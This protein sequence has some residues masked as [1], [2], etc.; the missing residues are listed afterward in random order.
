MAQEEATMAQEAMMDLMP[1]AQIA[2]LGFL[3]RKHNQTTGRKNSMEGKYTLCSNMSS[4][5]AVK[6]S[7]ATFERNQIREK[8]IIR[9]LF[10]IRMVNTN[11]AKRPTK[12]NKVVMG[13]MRLRDTV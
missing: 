4:R 6:A 1:M 8:A 12:E 7:M 10:A 13:S 11:R 9:Y 5:L 3:R 2:G